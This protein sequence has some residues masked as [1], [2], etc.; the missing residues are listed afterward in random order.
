MSCKPIELTDV[1]DAATFQTGQNSI[2]VQACAQCLN[3]ATQ[4]TYGLRGSDS[5]PQLI[6]R[7]QKHRYTHSATV[8]N[9]QGTL[10]HPPLAPMTHPIGGLEPLSSLPPSHDTQQY[11]AHH[12]GVAPL[13]PLH[14][15][16]RCGVQT[17]GGLHPSLPSRLLTPTQH[18]SARHWGAGT[19]LSPPSSSTARYN[20]HHKGAYPR[21]EQPHAAMVP[22][23][24]ALA[25]IHQKF[26]VL[27]SAFQCDLQNHIP[28]AV[29]HSV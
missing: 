12:W 2:W 11:S 21:F 6:N 4:M 8:Q 10:L 13:S 14:H 15:T 5:P 23:T 16:K 27:T 1:T 20:G 28:H 24:A 18:Y 7:S 25:Y 29:E 9:N 3:V 19:P 17:I 26:L 22:L